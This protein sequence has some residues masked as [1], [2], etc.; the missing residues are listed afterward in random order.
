MP[1]T[2]TALI[3]GIDYDGMTMERAI[4]RCR[5]LVH[6]TGRTIVLKGR[7]RNKFIQ[8]GVYEPMPLDLLPLKTAATNMGDPDACLVHLNLPK[9]GVAAL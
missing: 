9:R 1:D 5:Q 4:A 3:N 8:L 7:V 2:F 6:E